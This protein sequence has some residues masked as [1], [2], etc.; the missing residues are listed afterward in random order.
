MTLH[1]LFR[2]VGFLEALSYVLLLFVAVPLKHIFQNPLG[3]RVLGLPHGLLFVAYL[4]LAYDLSLKE[5]WP[6]KKLLW[7]LAGSVLPFGPLLF[8]QK[9]FR[10]NK[11]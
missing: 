9:Y 8:D 1:R 7:A 11:A 4:C 10:K 3:V 5:N 6:R 2:I